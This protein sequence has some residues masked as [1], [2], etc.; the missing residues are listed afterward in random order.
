VLGAGSRAGR[1]AD[2]RVEAGTTLQPVI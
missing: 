2:A 1:D